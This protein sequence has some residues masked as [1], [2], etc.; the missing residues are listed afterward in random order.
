[1]HRLLLLRIFAGGALVCVLLSVLVGCAGQMND[2]LG[3]AY[4]APATLNLRRE[5]TE[6]NGSVAVLKHGDLVYI[7]ELR[8]RFVRIRAKG[9]AE[10]WV[11]SVQLLPPD[12]MNR[13]RRDTEYALALP[14]E[15]SAGVYEALN[16]HLDPNRQSP[17]FARI[18]ESGSVEVL[19]HKLQPKL[20]PQPKPPVFELRS[21][22][23]SPPRKAKSKK[24]GTTF[25]LPAPPPPPRAPQNWLEL[26]PGL[27]DTHADAQKNLADKKVQ[28]PGK[29]VPMEDWSL[30][31]TKDKQ[32]GWVLSRNLVMSVPDE[33]AQYAE[34]KRIT[35]YFDIGTVQDE[36][37]GVKHNWLWTTASELE[38]YDFDAWRVFLWNRHRHRYE[39]SYRQRDVE[40]YFPVHVDPVENQSPQRTFELITRDDDGK[41]RRR[42]YLFDGVR[43]HLQ[44]QEDIKSAAAS[45][46][47]ATPSEQAKPQEK[48]RRPNWM[49]RE[50]N[51]LKQRFRK[52]S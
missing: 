34:G 44:G 2:T 8:R 39:T 18:P 14:S 52:T 9:G 29:P 51:Q 45:T 16:I 27:V 48:V 24:A 38:E 33:V 41:L 30:V 35:S 32:C 15:G 19:E 10:G 7:L 50:W 42:T 12:E 3:V 40:G 1:M 31:R 13:I 43:V 37:K 5:L 21:L 47:A 22:H 36:E 4:V 11:D 6:K 17:A 46:T 25:R 23:T 28:A 49:L 26:S 20:S